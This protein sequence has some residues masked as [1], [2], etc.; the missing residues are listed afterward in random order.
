M[1]GYSTLGT[2]DLQAA[3][4][5]YDELFALF[6]A[7]RVLEQPGRAVYYGAGKLE[8][9]VLKPFNGQTATVGNGAMVALQAPSRAKVREAFDLV[10]QRGGA[11]EGAP[12]IRGEDPNGF[13][14]AYMRDLDGNKLCIFRFGPDTPTRDT[15][16]P[17]PETEDNR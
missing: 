5:F 9:G 2:N 1:L 11:D 16:T 8:F 12:G 17:N 14:G 15:P 7:G 13:Y 10:L 3:T 6:G 4:A